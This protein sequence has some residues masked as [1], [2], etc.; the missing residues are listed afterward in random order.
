LR[1]VDNTGIQSQATVKK[2]EDIITSE[3]FETCMQIAGFGPPIAFRCDKIIHPAFC[4]M[5]ILLSHVCILID[6][7]DEFDALC[8]LC[9]LN[10]LY[11]FGLG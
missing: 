4:T 5:T 11:N 3:V 8:E 2:K 10:P 9:S 6:E 7:H 1:W